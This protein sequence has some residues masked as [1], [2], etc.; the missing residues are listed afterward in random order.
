MSSASVMDSLHNG[1]NDLLPVFSAKELFCDYNLIN[2]NTMGIKCHAQFFLKPNSVE[3]FSYLQAV[4]A[5]WGFPV[6]VIGAG[7][8]VLFASDVL[9]GCVVS[10]IGIRSATWIRRTDGYDVIAQAGYPIKTLIREMISKNLGGAEFLVG[11]P[12]SVGGAIVGNAGA[13]GRG[14]GDIV[15]WVEVVEPTGERTVYHHDS[16]TWGYRYCSLDSDKKI[17]VLSCLHLAFMNGHDAARMNCMNFWKYRSSQPFLGER[18]AGCIFKNPEG[19]S[20]GRLLDVSGCKGLQH[21]DACISQ[22]HANFII[23]QKN[24]TCYDVIWLINKCKDVVKD[25]ANID[26]DL[27]VKIL[28]V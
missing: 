7:S 25:Y 5:K 4:R 28:G 13:Q 17:V 22:K 3:A 15:K 10:T 9:R 2:S 24:A 20:A 12:G 27:E 1:I 16:I 11:I 19:N 8:N 18:S 6:Y 26:L 21:G 23:N 14:I